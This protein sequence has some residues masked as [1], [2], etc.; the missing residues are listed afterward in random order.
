VLYVRKSDWPRAERAFKDAV[1]REPRSAEAHLTLGNFYDAR[2]DA[3]GAERAL[4]LATEAV[5]SR[6]TFAG[7]DEA[8]RLLAEVR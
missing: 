2:H 3:A 4:K 7:K 1:D 6:A 5:A 8:R